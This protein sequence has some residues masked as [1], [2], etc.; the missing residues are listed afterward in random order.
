MQTA[1]F[2]HVSGEIANRDSLLSKPWKSQVTLN[3]MYVLPWGH[4]HFA[5][6]AYCDCPQWWTRIHRRL[7]DKLI[8][9]RFPAVDGLQK[10]TNATKCSYP[11]K[12]IAL[13]SIQSGSCRHRWFYRAWNGWKPGKNV[14]C[15]SP[16][17][18]NSSCL[19]TIRSWN[20]SSLS[21]QNWFK[22]AFVCYHSP[23]LRLI[24]RTRK[25]QILENASKDYS[26]PHPSFL[27]VLNL[28]TVWAKAAGIELGPS[29]ESWLDETT[30]PVIKIFLRLGMPSLLSKRLR[31]KIASFTRF[32]CYIVMTPWRTSSQDLGRTNKGSNGNATPVLFNMTVARLVLASV[33][34]P[35]IN[36]QGKDHAGYYPEATDITL[37]LLFDPTSGKYT[38][39]KELGSKGV[40]K[41]IDILATAIRGNLTFDLPE[42][43]FTMRHHLLLPRIPSSCSLE[44]IEGLLKTMF[45]G[46]S[47]KT[48]WLR[49]RNSLIR[50][51]GDLKW[52]T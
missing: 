3:P 11:M 13:P 37:K 46:T 43:E 34:L 19:A 41:R 21:K 18:K 39:P 4:Q 9:S 23:N 2:P 45:N 5:S 27:S 25:N 35:W 1:D 22:T 16:S 48:N 6:R 10:L 52:S 42:L 32:S 47:S 50:T 36:F 8:L 17:S 31:A 28:K 20:G 7:R 30:K 12:Y 49:E 24:W 29:A 40:D 38:V 44:P 14:V 51:S 33:S 15:M 26:W